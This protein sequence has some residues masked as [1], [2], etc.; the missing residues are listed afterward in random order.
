M[1]R[2]QDQP[3]PSGRIEPPFE[4]KLDPFEVAG[5]FEC[6]LDFFMA[7]RELQRRHYHFNNRD[8]DYLAIPRMGATFWA[9]TAGMLY[10]YI[11]SLRTSH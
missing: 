10:T 5:Y 9:P 11:G 4:L 6:P 2:I 7:P 8:R 1:R 3:R